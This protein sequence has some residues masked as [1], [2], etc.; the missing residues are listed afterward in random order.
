[1]TR[2]TARL[3]TQI[4]GLAALLAV[5]IVTYPY[6]LTPVFQALGSALGWLGQ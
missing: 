1:M 5:A 4:T 3:A 6:V 2:T